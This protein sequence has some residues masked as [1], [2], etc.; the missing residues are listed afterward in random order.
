[1]LSNLFLDTVCAFRICI[2]IFS[3]LCPDAEA[4][5]HLH[6]RPEYRPTDTTAH[7]C[8]IRETL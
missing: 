7:S 2:R 3:G 8:R 5:I 1:M 4:G 6:D